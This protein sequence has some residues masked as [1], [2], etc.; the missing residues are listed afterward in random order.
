MS[1]EGSEQEEAGIRGVGIQQYGSSTVL[2]DTTKPGRFFETGR[3][4]SSNPL[5]DV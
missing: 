3:A 2:H 5:S 1:R 4:P